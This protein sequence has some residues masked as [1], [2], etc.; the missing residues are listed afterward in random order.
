MSLL[1]SLSPRDW[2]RDMS[3]TALVAGFVATLVGFTSSIA[4]IFQAAHGLGASTEETASWIWALCMACGLTSLLPSLLLRKPVMMAWSTPGA[5]VLATA[6][7]SGQ[8]TLGQAVGAFMVSSLLIVA[9]GVSG[10]FERVMDRIPMAVAAALLAGVLARFAMQ[11]FGAAGTAPGLVLSMLLVY[12]LGK[13]FSARYAMLWTLIA[14]I[15]WAAFSGML[16]TSALAFG[17]AWPVFIEPDFHWQAIVSLALPLFVVTM[18]SQNLPGVAAFRAAGYVLPV[19]PLITLTGMVSLVLAPF[20]CYAINFSAITASIC[21]GREAHEDPARRYMAAA[22]W[23]VL[24]IVIGIGGVMVAG[25]LAAFPMQLV[26]AVAG[27][28]LLSTIASSLVAGLG[29]ERHREV[30][31]ITFLV[32]LSGVELLGI[33]SAFWGVVA[34]MVALLVQEGVPRRRV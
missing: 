5:V 2:M 7:A 19:S 3:L 31:V 28:A 20:G 29:P 22:V 13:R 16:D 27:L 23:G 9:C 21:M 30:A 26:Q 34:G 25:L 18:A 6:A 32:T 33:G 10:W 14:G 8:F 17:L 4:I 12:L 15:A 1:S 24:M 11:A